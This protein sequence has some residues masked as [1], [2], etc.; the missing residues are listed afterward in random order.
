MNTVDTSPLHSRQ[1]PE[2]NYIAIVLFILVFVVSGSA[3]SSVEVYQGED[4]DYTNILYHDVRAEWSPDGAMIAYL[5]N[6][7][8]ADSSGLAL[9]SVDDGLAYMAVVYG[10][11][12]AWSPLSD[13]V[14]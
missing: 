8:S 5:H 7:Y 13:A 12:P 11:N 6:D 10:D 4:D 9:L 3:C 2:R 14:V 1:H